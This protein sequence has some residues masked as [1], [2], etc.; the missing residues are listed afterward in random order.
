MEGYYAKLTAIL[1]EHGYY[2]IRRGK[3]SHEI[4][5]NEKIARPVPFH[6]R[7]RYTANGILKQFGL[8]EKL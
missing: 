4:W 2:L 7:N 6:C 5:G 3:G 8:K 1:R